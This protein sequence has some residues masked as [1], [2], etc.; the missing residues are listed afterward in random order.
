MSPV[1]DN[2]YLCEYM[3]VDICIHCMCACDV[4]KLYG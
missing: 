4:S 2:Y 1:R 3:Y